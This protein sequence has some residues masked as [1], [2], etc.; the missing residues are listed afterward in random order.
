MNELSRPGTELLPEQQAIWDKCVHPA[1]TFIEFKKEEVEQSIPSR[2]EKMVRQYPDRIAV[3]TREQV[4]TYD[5]LNRAANRVA[6]AIHHTCGQK[7]EPIVLLCEH[8]P[9][10]IIACLGILKAGKIFVAVDPWFPRERI[11]YMADDSNARAILTENN[12]LALATTLANEGRSIINIDALDGTLPDHNV[13]L[14]LPPDAPAQIRYTSGST[15]RPKGVLRSHRRNIYSNFLIINEAHICP[16]DRLIILRTLSFAAQDIFKGLLIGA[17]V[18]PFDIRKQGLANLADFLVEQGITFYASTPSVFRYFINELNGEDKFPSVRLILLGGEP[19]FKREVE[20]YKKHF[21]DNCMLLNHLSSN[22]TGTFCQYL[23]TK[24][25]ELNTPIVPV[26]YPVEGK[27]IVLLD[28]DGRDVG[29]SQVGEIAVKSRYL[30]DGYWSSPEHTDGKFL[31]DP[32]GAD[33]RVYRTG[34]LGQLLPN[35]CLVYF[36]RK[37]DQ[38]KIRGCKV[39]ISEVQGL[40]LE[41]PQVKHA[42]I[43]ACEREPGEK[44]LAGY[45]V[46][47]QH[48]AL[49]VTE[50]NEFLRRKL[51]GYMIPSVFMFVESLP[52]TNGKLDRASLPT[53]PDKSR[54][55][56]DTPFV[57]PRTL[58]EIQVAQIWAHIL[59]LDQVGIHDN[60]FDLGGHS[61]AA[62]RVVS[63]VIKKFQLEIPLQSLFQS[64]TIA[65]MA[66]VITQSQAKKLDEADLNH[67]LAELESLTD[68]EAQRLL[69][70]QS[71]TANTRDR[72]E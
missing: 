67:I 50:L 20:S 70:D 32:A 54:P 14:Q 16:D 34:D 22:E 37:D 38:V 43:L 17:G 39:H 57:I 59:S 8:G 72:H 10:A 53:P 21:S 63:Q 24:E 4:L 28:D 29:F 46:P 64:P 71:G 52:L 12:N 23:I 6:G 41:H 15:G 47:R 55:V 35:G 48:A 26:G 60:F 33:E 58:T 9:A 66:E 7:L 5:E 40:L 31:P 13:G 69:S 68:E 27:K 19:L 44:Y 1:G 49:T 45:I 65:E 62:T 2:F 56:L 11:V 25:T 3:K 51:P 61:L 18:F 30:S 42:A 36:G